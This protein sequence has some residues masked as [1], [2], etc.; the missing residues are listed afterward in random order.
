MCF[1]LSGTQA[2]PT[3]DVIMVTG[4]IGIRTT[5]MNGIRDTG[6]FGQK[7]MGYGILRPPPPLLGRALDK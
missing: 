1:S 2:Y 5:R 4:I 7:L 6:Y 3:N